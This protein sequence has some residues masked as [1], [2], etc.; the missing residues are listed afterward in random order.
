MGVDRI[1]L[2]GAAGSGTTT[3]GRALAQ[4]LH[5]PHFDTDDYFWLPTN[6]PY[7]EVRDAAERQTLLARDLQSREKWVLSGSLCGWGDAMIPFFDLTVFLLVPT[8]TRLSRLAA[9]EEQRFGEALQPDGPMYDHHR[10]F[11]QWAADY[12]DGGLD[13]RS[14]MRHEQR[15][16]NLPGPVLRLEGDGSV[17]QWLDRILAELNR[18]QSHHH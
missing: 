9:R 4:H 5:F 15:L 18:L 10:Q 11:M 17:R 13:M 2:F 14:R 8:D 16:E 12:D 1:H 3:M 7:H 6:P